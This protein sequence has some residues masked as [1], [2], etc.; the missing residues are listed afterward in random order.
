M[1]IAGSIIAPAGTINLSITGISR[2]LTLQS[3]SYLQASGVNLIDMDSAVTG[4]SLT[5][6]TLDGGTITLE[7]PNGNIV[8]ESGSVI[9]V[10]GSTPVKSLSYDSNNSI[11][12]KTIASD[13]GSLELSYFGDLTLEGELIGN[14]YLPSA[15]GASLSIANNDKNSGLALEQADM[16]YYLQSGFDALAFSSLKEISFLSDIDVKLGR[17]LVLDAPLISASEDHDIRFSASSISLANTRDKYGDETEE[18]SYFGLVSD[19]QELEVKDASLTLAGEYIDVTGSIALS[20]FGST[21]LDAAGDIQLTDEVYYDNMSSLVWKGQLRTS[22]DLTLRAARIYPTTLS[23]FTLASDGRITILPGENELDT[24]IVSAGG[25]LTIAASEIDHQGYLAA[26]MGSIRF[27]KNTQTEDPADRIFFSSSS[28][29]TIASDSR[30]NYGTLE[31]DYWT[32]EEKPT[33][34]TK[35]SSIQPVTVEDVPERRVD[36][37][38]EEVIIQAGAVIDSSGGGSIFAFEF[39]A[40]T[41][42]LVDPF[43]ASGTYVVVPG[44]CYGGTAVYLAGGGGLPAGTYT[45]L[46]EEYAFL[47]GAYVIQHIGSADSLG[48]MN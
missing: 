26:P 20:G 38:G 28:V 32:L 31:D 48:S 37:S 43:L 45:L 34:L 47:D 33:E 17:S 7:A 42:G 29:T 25:S 24:P 36:I 22:G 9:D 6:E 19:S 23:D 44:I 10:S 4:Q 27:I 39:Q 46:S 35:K 5:Y 12:K 1:D 41:D 40:G 8:I 11:V 21:T 14:A 3:G 16:E 30:V 2:D 18:I 13:A 15:Y